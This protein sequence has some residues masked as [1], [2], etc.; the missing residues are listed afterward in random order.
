MSQ[1]TA[2]EGIEGAL[3]DAAV[4]VDLLHLEAGLIVGEAGGGGSSGACSLGDRGQFVAV[5]GQNA[6]RRSQANF[7]KPLRERSFPS[8]VQGLPS[9][10]KG[11]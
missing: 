8:L 7:Q 5:E 2:A 4:G 3:G 9:G 10:I 1:A 11:E 6:N